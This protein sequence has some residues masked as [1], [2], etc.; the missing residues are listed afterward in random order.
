MLI[1]GL[2]V[3]PRRFPFPLNIGTDICQVSRIYRLLASDRGVRFLQR[4]F[5][6]DERT[7]VPACSSS[8]QTSTTKPES[9][10]D[11]DFRALKKH[12]P[13]LWK[14]ATFVAGR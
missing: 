9:S 6:K 5:T 8:G 4:V 14:R 2:M 7:L 10:Q 1:D 3:S 13:L 12:N 11:G